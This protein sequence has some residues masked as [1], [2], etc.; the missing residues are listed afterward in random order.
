MEEVAEAPISSDR[1]HRTEPEAPKPPR[2]WLS[3]KGTGYWTSAIKAL[4]GQSE[5][6]TKEGPREASDWMYI[7]HEGNVLVASFG[8]R[9]S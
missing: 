5:V 4:S 2:Y 3:M 6:E 1:A 8:S 7:F 9:P